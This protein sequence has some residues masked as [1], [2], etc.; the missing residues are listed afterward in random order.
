VPDLL[1]ERLLLDDLDPAT[2]ADVRARLVATGGLSRLTEVQASNSAILSAHPSAAVLA[3][4]RRRLGDSRSE[5]AAARRSRGVTSALWALGATAAVA[6]LLVVTRPGPAPGESGT[7]ASPSRPAETITA[8]GLRP[9]LVIYRKT[10]AGPERLTDASRVRPGDH[11]QVAYVAAGRRFG[12]V[13]SQDARGTVT[14]HLPAAGA[15]AVPLADRG[16]IAV[17]NAF[18]LDDSPEFE[19]FVFVTSNDPFP[20]SAIVEALRRKSKD[21]PPLPPG[22]AMMEVVLVKEAK[23]P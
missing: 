13:A 4:V 20:A 3:E 22:T 9:H 14:L 16:E 17:A 1:V 19:R 8:K 23:V 15:Q 10:P 12:I 21:K 6:I 18:E 5:L 2:A 7:P 11:L